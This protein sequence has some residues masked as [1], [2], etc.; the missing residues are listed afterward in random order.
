MPCVVERVGAGDLVAQQRRAR[1]PGAGAPK[2]ST[3]SGAR[4]DAPGRASSSM[5]RRMFVR[6]IAMPS[7]TAAGRARS[8]SVVPSIAAIT[9]PTVPATR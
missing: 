8:G 6:C 9:T 5:S 2:R 4:Y 7:A 1:G 3:V